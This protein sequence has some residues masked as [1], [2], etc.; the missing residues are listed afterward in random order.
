[1]TEEIKEQILDS[2]RKNHGIVIDRKDPIF[3]VLTANDIIL[4]KYIHEVEESLFLQKTEIEDITKKYLLA[5]KELAEKR[6]MAALQE[7]QVKLEEKTHKSTN[8]NHCTTYLF[9]SGVTGVTLGY[10]LA[11]FIL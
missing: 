3:A 9:L 1:M 4:H 2:I 5:T 11:L 10:G 6:L 8:S 7:A